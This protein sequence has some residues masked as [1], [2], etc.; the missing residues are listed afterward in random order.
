VTDGEVAIAGGSFD[1]G[2]ND[3]GNA[4][5]K[6][7]VTVSPFVVD[8]TEVS[9]AMYRVCVDCGYCTPPSRDGSFSGREP[10]YGNPEFDDYPVIHVTW[11]QAMD[12]CSGLGKRLPTE[13]EWEFM[14]R[15]AEDRLYPW[16]N[17]YPTWELVNAS[18]FM[19]DTIRVTDQAAGMNPDGVLNL[20]GNVWDWIQDVYDQDY[21]QVGPALD[22]QGPETGYSMVVRGG[23]FGSSLHN[24]KTYVRN[25]M[26]ALDS[27]SNVGFRCAY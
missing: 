27:Y 24:I 9:N 10:Y 11:E 18:Y 16:G 15:G 1:M 8:R 20:S 17:D 22:P 23:S 7:E 3:Q 12:Y 4:F 25:E 26:F 14:A 5:P 13:A 21:Y 19:G 6:H 2:T